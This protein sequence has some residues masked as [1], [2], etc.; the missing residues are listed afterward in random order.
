MHVGMFV[1]TP[2]PQKKK[3]CFPA[4]PPFLELG[5]VSL[6]ICSDRLATANLCLHVETHQ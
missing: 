4:S 3:A 6:Q 5:D 2:P 1:N